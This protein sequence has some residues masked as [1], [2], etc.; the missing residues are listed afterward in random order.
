[1]KG[2]F[3]VVIIVFLW[4]QKTKISQ[5]QFKMSATRKWRNTAL[6]LKGRT[7]PDS[8]KGLWLALEAAPPHERERL[9]NK[10][11]TQRGGRPCALHAACQG[12]KPGVVQWLITVAGADANLPMHGTGCTPLHVAC[13]CRNTDAATQV[14]SVL[15][16]GSA[17]LDV[18]TRNAVGW[19]PLHVAVYM[20]NAAVVRLLL[21]RAACTR[22]KTAAPCG[23][24]PAGA[25]PT[26]MAEA[27]GHNDL[28]PLLHNPADPHHSQQFTVQKQLSVGRLGTVYHAKWNNDKVPRD[29]AVKVVTIDSNDAKAVAACVNEIRQMLA[30]VHPN[31]VAYY[32]AYM[33]HR[34]DVMLPGASIKE[35]HI[36]MEYCQE[37]SLADMTRAP[38]AP[39]MHSIA[40]QLL[41]AVAALHGRVPP[42][43]HMDIKPANVCLASPGSSVRLIDL[44]VANTSLHTMT[45]DRHAGTP[46]FWS[47][48]R[49]AGTFGP[50]DDVWAAGL[51]LLFLGTGLAGAGDLSKELQSVLPSSAA[52]RS[53]LRYLLGQFEDAYGETL[54]TAL[55]MMLIP[56]ADD[57]A[58]A[59][60]VVGLL[61]Q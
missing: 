35:L 24:V 22:L 48:E 14:V 2:G 29:L 28:L 13:G 40:T 16:S 18:D 54:G 55:R 59:D 58:T 7:A 44:G 45:T 38:G 32:G 26:D 46:A 19:T 56:V 8:H 6:W 60:M 51:T 37:G 3:C 17:A 30:V 15:L 21:G 5:P 25:S 11:V 12:G 10:P 41:S 57:R 27:L 61:R 1:M 33:C 50:K 39:L 34:T 23:G 49:C 52:Y 36:L 9:V 47:P 43:Q 42:V 4:L 53:R 31:I 20:N